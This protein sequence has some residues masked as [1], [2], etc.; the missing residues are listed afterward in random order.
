MGKALTG[1]G[2][3]SFERLST[4]YKTKIIKTKNSEVLANLIIDNNK[5]ITYE[6]AEGELGDEIIVFNFDLIH[7]RDA[8]HTLFAEL[9]VE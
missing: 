8:F 9:W 1:W 3:S 2:K 5:S 6:V 4:M 7:E